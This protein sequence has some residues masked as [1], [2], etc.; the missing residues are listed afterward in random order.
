MLFL[1]GSRRVKT[2]RASGAGPLDDA[3]RSA[4]L[5]VQG[6][7]MDNYD[8]FLQLE[9]PGEVNRELISFLSE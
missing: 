3:W 6:K 2:A 5:K 7:D 8:H 9:A 4:F 1:Y